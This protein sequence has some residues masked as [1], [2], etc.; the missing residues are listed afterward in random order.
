MFDTYIMRIQPFTYLIELFLI[1]KRNAEMRLQY[2]LELLIIDALAACATIA[3]F[4]IHVC[5]SIE[6]CSQ[7]LHVGVELISFLL[8]ILV[9]TRATFC[10]GIHFSMI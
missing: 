6:Y 2:F 4:F 8:S 9:V 1:F 5:D 7:L 10:F 3:V